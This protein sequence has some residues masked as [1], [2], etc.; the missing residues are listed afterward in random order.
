MITE[1]KISNENNVGK[2]DSWY[3]N[4]PDNPSEFRYGQTET[5]QLASEFLKDCDIVEDWGCGAGGFLRYREDAIGVDGSDTKFATKKFIDLTKYVSE[6]DGINIR[7]VFEHNYNWSSI[8][9]NSLKS[10]KKKICITM[11]VPLSETTEEISHNLPHGV[12]VPDLRI[13]KKEFMDIINKFSPKSVDSVLLNTATGY[14]MEEI[15]Y[16]TM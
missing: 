9:E 16:I 3:K 6:C 15:I 5:Y 14:G 2:W 7:H 10:A 11:F 4:L 8:L 1:E 12:D 13:S